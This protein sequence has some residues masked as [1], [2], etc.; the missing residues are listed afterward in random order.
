MGQEKEL[1]LEEALA[2]I[3]EQKTEIDGLSTR[4]ED[5]EG[6]VSESTEIISGLQ[7]QLAN[8]QA[9]QEISQTVVVTHTA[10]DG[11]KEQYKVLAPKFQHKH[12]TYAAADLKTNADLVKE[13][14]EAKSGVLVKLEKAAK[15]PAKKDASK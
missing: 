5:L 10:E 13:L 1:T 6:E 8:A 7:E 9:G 4:V 15:A 14:V 2:K 12:V 11:T 3:A